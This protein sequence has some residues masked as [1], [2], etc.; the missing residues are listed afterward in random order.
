MRKYYPSV[1]REV[2]FS[3]LERD[4]ANPDLVWLVEALVSTHRSG[5]NIG[6]YLSQFLA[7]YYMAPAVRYACS[8]F[9]VR[10]GRRG[11]PDRREKLVAH[12]LTYM[13]DWFM[14][15]RDKANLKSAVRKVDRFLRDELRL[16]IKPWKVCRIDCE[17]VDMVG[18]VFRRDRTTVRAGTF[19]RARRAFRRASRA[20]DL[21]PHVAARA[22]AYWGYFK[23][24]DT[25]RFRDE[26]GLGAIVAR[27]R[28]VM[29]ACARKGA[30]HGT[31]AEH[32]AATP[33][34]LLPAV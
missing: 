4:V 23:S 15:G 26:I 12:V 9:R 6:S 7:N 27:C 28:R 33:L 1:S 17:P 2:L 10:R 19:I 21:S 16:A 24:T 3:M 14:C 25:R 8:L 32:H 18:F 29:S 5:I 11:R 31:H 30:T 20:R 22:I 34:R 13:D